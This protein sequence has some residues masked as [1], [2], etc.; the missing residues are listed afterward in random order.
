MSTHFFVTKALVAY[1]IISF[2]GGL[3]TLKSGKSQTF[4]SRL[5][6]H[7]CPAT[8]SASSGCS[9]DVRKHW[10]FV[11]V[12]EPDRATG[13]THPEQGHLTNAQRYLRCLKRVTRWKCSASSLVFSSLLKISSRYWSR[14]YCT[15]RQFSGE[16]IRLLQYCASPPTRVKSII[17]HQALCCQSSIKEDIKGVF[18]AGALSTALVNKTM[19]ASDFFYLH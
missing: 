9:F 4:T 7:V 6:A 5:L 15:I 14:R 18:S 8:P 3:S 2:S 17:I 1:S 16:P 10:I 12:V 19:I 13:T 11:L